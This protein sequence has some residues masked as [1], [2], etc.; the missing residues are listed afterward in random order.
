MFVEQVQLQWIVFLDFMQCGG[1]GQNCF[2]YCC[3]ECVFG[4]VDIFGGDVYVI[5][6]VFYIVEEFLYGLYECFGI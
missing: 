6:I 2:I 5:G 3:V 1:L 4:G